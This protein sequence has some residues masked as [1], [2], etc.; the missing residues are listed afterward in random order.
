MFRPSWIRSLFCASLVALAAV[1]CASS[2]KPPAQ[3]P[4]QQPVCRDSPGD[5]V[6]MAAKTGVAGA[7]T[8]VVTAVE[9]VKT[10]GR[11][12]VGFVKGGSGEA[13]RQWNE[14][15]QDTRQVARESAAETRREGSV[16]VCPPAP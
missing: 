15:K 4:D 1:G 2:E 10:A 7:K 3:S 8:G 9:G 6:Q 11:A 13:G 14:G 12:T 5:D 16:P